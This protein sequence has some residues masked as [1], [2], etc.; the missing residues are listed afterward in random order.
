MRGATE[1]LMMVY[2]ASLISIHA[3]HARS[4][5]AALMRC[6]RHAIS[7]HAPHAR[8]DYRI[9]RDS[10]L[11][12]ISIHAP[13]ARSDH[14]VSDFYGFLGVFQS[15]LLMRGATAVRHPFD[16]LFQIS[17]HAPHARSDSGCLSS[18]ERIIISI[19]AP[20]ARSDTVLGQ[21]SHS[22]IYFNPR[23]SCEERRKTRKLETF[24]TLFQSTL[25]MRGA[26]PPQHL[27]SISSTISIHAPH[28]RSDK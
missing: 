26:T 4:D 5:V 7:I 3:P 24:C 20:H 27:H 8:I 15:T 17:I 2:D 23:S 19:H 11:C 18:V 22:V 1:E 13:H 16:S 28:A 9:L 21:P 12:T 6:M 14:I 10:R 25:L